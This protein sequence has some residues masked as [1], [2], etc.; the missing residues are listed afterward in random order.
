MS[1]EES[2]EQKMEVA[3]IMRAKDEMPYPPKTLEALT[4][5]TFRDF[6]LYVVDSGSSDGTLEALKEG[7]PHKMIEIAPEDYVPG[8]VL[9]QMVSMAKEPIIVFLNADAIPIGQDWLEKLIDPI[10]QS[11]AD[12]TMSK[13]VT[14][15]S[16]L[17]IVDYDY[18]RAFEPKN[19]KK[20]NADFFSAVSC[21]FRRNMWE[22][23]RFYEDGYAE[24]LVWA[25]YHRKKGAKFQLILDSVVEHSHNY[26]IKALHKKKYRHG[27]VFARL[28]GQQPQLIHQ[29]YR[30]LREWVRDGLEALK[31]GKF[32]T[33]LYNFRYRLTIHRALYQGLR[34]GAALPK[35]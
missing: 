13:Q 18:R 3:I 1:I 12:A 34:D 5:Q 20:E 35:L 8:R 6:R 22:E 17:F 33:V 28:Y 29:M 27:V 11:E 10:R 9:N 26:S 14:R 21:A 7:N 30:C 23:K 31:K 25:A 24:D 32:S 16:A 4:E 19:I 15:D 2:Q